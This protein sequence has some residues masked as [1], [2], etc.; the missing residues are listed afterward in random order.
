MPITPILV[1][2][3]TSK[4]TPGGAWNK[5]ALAG[6]ITGGAFLATSLILFLVEPSD[7]PIEA[8]SQDDTQAR[9]NLFPLHEGGFV[10]Q[11]GFRF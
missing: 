6:Y 11:Y 3:G 5:V 9:L 10:V 8:G 2:S 7:E 4:V 1:G